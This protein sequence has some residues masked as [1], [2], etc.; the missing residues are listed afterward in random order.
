MSTYSNT[1]VY[2]TQYNKYDSIYCGNE[3]F[4]VEF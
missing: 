1:H 3:I 4:M 2:I